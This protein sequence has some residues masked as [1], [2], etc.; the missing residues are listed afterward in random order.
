[1]KKVDI[2]F[3]ANPR[4]ICN[5]NNFHFINN[6][7]YMQQLYTQLLY[8]VTPFYIFHTTQYIQTLFYS[9]NTSYMYNLYF[10]ANYKVFLRYVGHS[11]VNDSNKNI[12]RTRF[13]LPS[14]LCSIQI[15]TYFN[16]LPFQLPII[17]H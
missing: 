3:A 11:L 10:T 8:T 13:K 12:N 6:Q 7:Y 1:M 4:V 14:R 16:Q 9:V 2:N 17:T 5:Y 15:Q